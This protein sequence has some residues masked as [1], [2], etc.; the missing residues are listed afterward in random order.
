MSPLPSRYYKILLPVLVFGAAAI[1]CLSVG[2]RTLHESKPAMVPNATTTAPST[3]STLSSTSSSTTQTPAPTAVVTTTPTPPLLQS[4]SQT[5]E[6]PAGYIQATLSVAGTNYPLVAP[7]NSTVEAAMKILE[8]QD[9]SFT[10]AEQ[11]YPDL[12]EFVES[13]NGKASA[14]GY[15]WFLYVN[16]KDSS[17]GASQTIVHSGDVIEWRYM[18]Q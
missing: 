12:G 9:P 7:L 11:S 17:T 6:V 4:P 14:N 8:S 16:G 3:A 2:Y 18:H 15:Y 1:L 5:I 13:I 10:F